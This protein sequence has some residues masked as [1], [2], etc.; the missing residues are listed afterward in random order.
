MSTTS[1][2][3]R[4]TAICA[5]PTV[6]R[7]GGTSAI[8]SLAASMRNFGLEVR[9]GAPRRSHASSLRIRFCRL[10]S[11]AAACRSRSTRCST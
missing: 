2:P 8:S 4:D 11:A 1:L 5:R 7:T 9:A 10:A 3:S 6:S